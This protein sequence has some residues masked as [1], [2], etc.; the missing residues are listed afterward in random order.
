MK[1]IISKPDNYNNSTPHEK[2]PIITVNGNNADYGF[3]MLRS[4]TLTINQ[5]FRQESKRVGRYQGKVEDLV[6]DVETFGLKEGDD[7]SRKVMPVKLIVKETTEPQYEGQQEKLYP[8][9]HAQAG[10]PVL[11]NGNYVYR[12][13]IIVAEGSDEHD[14]LLP[15][16]REEVVSTEETVIKAEQEAFSKSK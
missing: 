4:I 1:A 5:G 7:F 2:Y 14:T 8:A 13:T 11:S 12:Q 16:D 10:Q 9:G 15:T 3:I 6:K